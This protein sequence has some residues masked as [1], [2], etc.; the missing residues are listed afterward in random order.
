M[1]RTC[2]I[3]YWR[4]HVLHLLYIPWKI[5][6]SKVKMMCTVGRT[7]KVPVIELKFV[8]CTQHLYHSP[9]PP[10]QTT[11]NP[12]PQLMLKWQVYT[13]G[14]MPKT[15]LKQPLIKLTPETN[16]LTILSEK[17]VSYLLIGKRDEHNNN[18]E[19]WKL[20]KRKN[21]Y[22]FYIKLS[23]SINELIIWKFTGCNIIEMYN[24]W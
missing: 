24:V 18:L 20:D 9:L 16:C 4:L 10:T 7:T 19:T 15:S 11:P 23:C 22:K 13:V 8:S 14:K 5:P 17:V 2:T 12:T 1:L 3:L 6:H 21:H